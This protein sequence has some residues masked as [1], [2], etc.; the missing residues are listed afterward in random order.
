MQQ[1]VTTIQGESVLLRPSQ[2]GD[3]EESARVWTPEL[4][5]MY[6]G[7]ATA[8]GRP[9]VESRRRGNEQMAASGEH[10]FAI[11]ACPEPA[12]R[13]DGRY[14][15]FV[16]LKVNDEEQSASYRI[17]IANPEYWGRGYGTEVARL[18]LRYAFETLGLH[19]VHLKVAAYNV[20]ARRCYEKSGFRVEGVLRQSF[21]V[22]G[23]WQDDVL[24][25][26]LRE[27][28][29][30]M[31]ATP[32]SRA[33]EVVIRSYRSSDH[34]K[35]MALWDACGF[36]PGRNDAEV[37]LSQRAAD[38]RGLILVAEQ[39]GQMLGTVMGVMDRG[40]GWVQRLA[41]DPER[42]R[43]GIGRSLTQEAERRLAALGAYRVVLL[44]RRDSPAAVGLYRGLGYETWE[45][46]VV[47][48]RRLDGEEET[49][50]G[51]QPH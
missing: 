33:G 45:P 19:R 29:E 12:E 13:A 1:L 36:E 18:M 48:S 44:A 8:A 10:H 25:A 49:Q 43:Q 21:Q 51:H 50:S 38:P 28:W 14:I 46:V 40:W 37:I 47:M 39:D 31:V 4:R 15:G 5:H 35:M 11:E 16:G 26:I 34:A 6:G 17:G 22:D 24:M 2:E 27:E 20:R 7:S 42:R 3:A 30:C 32:I 23:E 9:T 41:V